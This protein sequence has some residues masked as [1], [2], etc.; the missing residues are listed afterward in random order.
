VRVGFDARPIDPSTGPFGHG[1]RG[2]G[3]YTGSLL[4]ALAE[5]RP[6]WAASHLRILTG[7][8]GDVGLPPGMV[9]TWRTQP[10]AIP[11]LETDWLL[12]AL[13]DRM[14]VRGAADLWFQTDVNRPLGP[15]PAARSIVA[16]H[17]LIPLDRLAR[18]PDRRIAYRLY[19]RRLRRARM[20]IAN[21]DETAAELR[22]R[23]G[24]PAARIRVVPPWIV[25]PGTTTSPGWPG[26]PGSPAPADGAAI[27]G[28]LVVGVAEP[29]KRFDLAVEVCGILRY[30]GRPLPLRIVG[31]PLPGE[32]QRLRERAAGL[33]I[34]S[35]VEVLGYVD[36]AT[37][38]RLYAS[39]VTLAVSAR[40]GLG[41]PPLE[42][43]LAGGRVAAVPLPVYAASLRGAAVFATGPEPN[44]IADAVERALDEAPPHAE[45][46]ALASR[47]SAEA[48]ASAFV[49]AV[50]AAARL[51]GL[52][53]LAGLDGLDGLDGPDAAGSQGAP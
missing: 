25:T 6:E 21:S 43:I 22:R 1:V 29:R 23:L 30:R 19:L 15:L 38:G 53:D 42:A 39:S 18:R 37:L 2:I 26:S 16:A 52:A 44:A 51:A 12:A 4:R 41:L 32:M 10:P 31:M 35:L 9:A 46:L 45:R 36:D 28:L 48:S 13:G 40:E 14:A 11:H 3:R 47:F 8:D 7:G 27:E 5:A 50:E 49:S 34:G 17:D 24:I 33:G 20:V